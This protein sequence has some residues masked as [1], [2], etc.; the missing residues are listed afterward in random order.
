MWVKARRGKLR[1][2]L[3]LNEYK[4]NIQVSGW[5]KNTE[6]ELSHTEKMNEDQTAELIYEGR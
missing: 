4:L 5:Y 6:G 1:N 2:K 3:M